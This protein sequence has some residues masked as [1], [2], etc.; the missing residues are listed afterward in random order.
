[1][2]NIDYHDAKPGSLKRCQIS[3]KDDLELVIDLGH[4]PLCDSLLTKEQL[5][6]PEKTFPLRLYRSKSLGH[7]QLDYVVP[8]EDVYYPEYPYRPGITNEVIEHHSKRA[9]QA[10]KRFNIN[11]NSLIIDI[12]SND[13][14]L[15][16]EYKKR[17]MK[18]LGIEPTNTGEFARERGIDTIQEFFTEDLGKQISS[19]Y[20]KAK[21]V[22][23]TNV[24]AHMATMGEVIR[25]ILNILDND[26]VFIFE[27]HYIIDILK[28]NQ[29]DTVYHE[30]IRSYSL[31]SIIYLFEMYGMKVIEAEVVDRYGGTIRVAVSM[32]KNAQVSNSINK[33]LS[34]EKSFGLF[35][36]DVW[37][38]FRQNTIK[39]KNDLMEIAINAANRGER[40]VGK[41]CPGRCSTLLNYA[42]MGKDLMPYIAEQPTS[43][44]LGLYLPGKHIP[45]ISDE[46]LYKEQPDYVVLLAWHY[47]KPIVKILRDNG[48]KSKFV[49]PLPE[50][51]I[52]EN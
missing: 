4:Q 32:D 20:G 50:V 23:A 9:D 11:T 43:L 1:M 2:K 35:E 34:Y 36:D 21:L 49:I 37:E 41:S 45:I 5:D 16:N 12:G 22:T 13:G 31:K 10:I 26:G 29:Y 51:K 44:K 25:G 28:G 46:I 52:L 42:G 7:G 17:N 39:S 27:N 6:S 3:N 24:F 48:L 30:H 8:G 18:V 38:K 47:W 19:D 40:F 15:L 33:L 14:T